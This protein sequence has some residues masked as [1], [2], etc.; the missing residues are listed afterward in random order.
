MGEIHIFI[1]KLDKVNQKIYQALL[2]N[3]HH[4]MLIGDVRKK[5]KY[6]SP[7]KDLIG[8]S[9]GRLRFK[10]ILEYLILLACRNKAE[11]R[12]NKG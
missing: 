12:R 6:Y 8:A 10:L 4:A 7:I 2:N 1:H 5:G 9:R 3:G 11:K